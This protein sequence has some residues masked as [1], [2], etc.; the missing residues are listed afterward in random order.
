M[1]LPLKETNK[2]FDLSYMSEIT[3]KKLKKKTSCNKWTSMNL[4]Y[5]IHKHFDEMLSRVY[6]YVCLEC[7][8][9]LW[10][11]EEENISSINLSRW[12]PLWKKVDRCCPSRTSKDDC[13]RPYAAACGNP[14][15]H[16]ATRDGKRQPKMTATTRTCHQYRWSHQP[17]SWSTNVPLSTHCSSTDFVVSQFLNVFLTH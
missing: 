7:E 12:N 4:L 8:I 1:C 6:I 15:W 5:Q 14:K 16:A 17:W 11:P 9:G 10:L 13:Q 3:V 2:R